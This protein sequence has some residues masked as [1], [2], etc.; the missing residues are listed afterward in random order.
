MANKTYTGGVFDADDVTFTAVTSGTYEH[1]V[2]WI[3]TGVEATSR[4]VACFD[5]ATGLP[6]TSSGGNV[7]V[8]FDSGAN[9]IFKL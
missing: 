6:V 1:L 7:I 4:L 9:K 3:D 8:T 2:I 5:T